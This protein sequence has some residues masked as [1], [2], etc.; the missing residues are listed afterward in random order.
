MFKV[1]TWLI[2]VRLFALPATAVPVLLGCSLAGKEGA[3]GVLPALLCFLCAFSMHMGVNLANDYFDFLKGADT[4]ECLGPSR[5]MVKGVISPESMRT[6]MIITLG[7]SVFFGLGLIPFGGWKL[8]FVG[9]T[10]LLV[11][12]GYTGGPWPLAYHGLGDV[13][14]ILFF[15]LVAVN[16]TYYVQAHHFSIDG[17]W[18]GLVSGLL[19]NNILVINNCRDRET[20][21]KAKKYTTVGLFGVRFS[22]YLYGFSLFVATSI[23]FFLW[24]YRG[25]SIAVLLPLLTLPIGML[26]LWKFIHTC[27]RALNALLEQ[28]ALYMVFF[29]SLL[30][31]GIVVS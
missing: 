9:I 13:V 15:G 19:S 30:A 6:A 24:K 31:F 23:P 20:D 2:A 8:I 14:Q 21:V 17:L 22:Y 27:G 16:F 25:F 4:P 29:G 7:V 28:T 10:C 18:V 3:F 26:L 1:K 11:G 5:L 12:L